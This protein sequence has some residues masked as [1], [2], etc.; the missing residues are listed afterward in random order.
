MLDIDH[1]SAY[2]NEKFWNR[3][4]KFLIKQQWD[5]THGY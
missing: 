1:K 3:L 4:V 2:V 5:N